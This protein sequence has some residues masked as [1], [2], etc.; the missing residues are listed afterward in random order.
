V[1]RERP[2]N[3]RAGN[4][5][6]EITSPHRLSRGPGPRQKLICKLRDYSRDLRT[7]K[8]GFRGQFAGSNPEPLMSGLRQTPAVWSTRSPP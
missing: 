8:W 2:C 1:R 6:D 3:G 5:F 7:A 4:F